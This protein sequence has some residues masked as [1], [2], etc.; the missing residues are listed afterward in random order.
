MNGAFRKAGKGYPAHNVTNRTNPI[1]NTMTL[2]YPPPFM[3]LAA[4]AQH[5]CCG[6]STI[7]VWVKQGAFPAP[8]KQGG[9]R[10]WRWKDVERHLAR[11]DDLAPSLDDQAVRIR[12]A[13]RAAVEKPH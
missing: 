9:K 11:A 3:D 13:T 6:E 4:L 7:E 1:N 8:V 5:I 2:P 12:E 10:L